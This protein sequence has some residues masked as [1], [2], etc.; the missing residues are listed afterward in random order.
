MHALQRFVQLEIR[1]LV[2]GVEIR[3]DRAGEQDGILRDD[4][5]ACA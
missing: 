1:E 5:Q 3:A 4:G 2:K